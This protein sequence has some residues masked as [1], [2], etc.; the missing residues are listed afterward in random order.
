MNKARLIWLVPVALLVVYLV[1]K[2]AE[3]P[4]ASVLVAE[5]AGN[6]LVM[7]DGER[8]ATAWIAE[9]QFYPDTG[10]NQNATLRA[11]RHVLEGPPGPVAFLAPGEPRMLPLR[12]RVDNEAHWE[13]LGLCIKAA[14]GAASGTA[15]EALPPMCEAATVEETDGVRMVRFR[16][17]GVRMYRPIIDEKLKGEVDAGAMRALGLRVMAE[18][19]AVVKSM[20]PNPT[21]E[22]VLAHFRSELPKEEVDAWYAMAIEQSR[23]WQEA[24]P[25]MARDDQGKPQVRHRAW[26]F[27]VPGAN[28]LPPDS[29]LSLRFPMGIHANV[30][31]NPAERN[32]ILSRMQGQLF[33]VEIQVLGEGNPKD[34]R[35]D[36][37]A[38][39]VH[40]IALKPEYF[41]REGNLT[42]GIFNFSGMPSIQG[43]LPSPAVS[44]SVPFWQ[45]GLELRQPVVDE[46][47]FSLAILERFLEEFAALRESRI[48]LEAYKRRVEE[49]DGQGRNREADWLYEQLT[50]I[51]P[52]NATNWIRRARN[53]SR[54]LAAS[55]RNFSHRLGHVKQAIS[56]LR[57]KAQEKLPDNPALHLALAETFLHKIAGVSDGAHRFYQR[58][59]VGSM[60]T[61]L[62]PTVDA[63]I[64]AK[65][66]PDWDVLA[67]PK[68]PEDIARVKRLREYFRMDPK[69]MREVDELHGA[70]EIPG[71]GNGT[72][73]KQVGL[74]WRLPET[75]AIYWAQRGL[76]F[77]GDD[78]RMRTD[79][80]QVI[81]Q[82]MQVTAQRGRIIVNPHLPGFERDYLTGRNW[83]YGKRL[84]FLLKVDAI[85]RQEMAT[86]PG[87]RSGHQQFLVGAVG[88]LFM[89]NRIPESR[90]WFAKL[91][92]DYPVDEPPEWEEVCLDRWQAR[93]V[94]NDGKE[95]VPYLESLVKRAYTLLAYDEDAMAFGNLRAA[96]MLHAR[97]DEKMRKSIPPFPALHDETLK[98]SLT[99]M[100]KDVPKLADA[101][102]QRLS[103]EAKAMPMPGFPTV[104]QPA[105]D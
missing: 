101:L 1:W 25:V 78:F 75:H 34:M 51:E 91:L 28:E 29:A 103:L 55:E 37:T 35:S 32:A 42:F 74:E 100:D 48:G 4:P 26:R 21:P 7:T 9:G 44:L 67:D 69:L 80:E 104:M 79:L 61:N 88:D 90:F 12:L 13:K 15:L 53:L 95:T 59:W 2:P 5:W 84:D 68:T 82:A 11:R 6:R 22:D 65:G 16:L 97:L 3:Q 73:K 43:R 56:L 85:F 52:E 58:T 81:D 66:R 18:H 57:D 19:P 36:F 39:T 87:L 86:N 72:I 27:Q 23:A 77:C 89:H 46:A 10:E 33:P 76:Q 45:G 64:Q 8:N 83:I 96:R 92:R 24:V 98:S 70:V 17:K 71:E 60:S 63:C 62:W 38:G 41:T 50:L 47:V 31:V 94:A 49:L 30:G 99:T 14:R 93:L 54:N 102:R 40:E 20:K 105:L